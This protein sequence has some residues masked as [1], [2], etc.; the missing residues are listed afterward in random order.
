MSGTTLRATNRRGLIQWAIDDAELLNAAC[1]AFHPRS[2]HDL[3]VTGIKRGMAII[4]I[5]KGQITELLDNFCED[6]VILK[7]LRHG[8]SLVCGTSHGEIRLHDTTDPSCPA[9]L[10][11]QAHSGSISDLV[12]CGGS[13]LT[14]G[15]HLRYGV[16]NLETAIKAF[17]ERSL[18]PLIPIQFGAGAAFLK[19][20][21]KLT[22]SALML[23]QAGQLQT[24]DVGNQADIS[25]RQLNSM[26]YLTAFDISS[27][28]DALVYTDAENNIHLY[29]VSHNPEPRFSNLPSQTVFPDFQGELP[30]FDMMS[31]P[32]HV[33]GMPYYREELFSSW[34]ASLV[35]EVGRPTPKIDADILQ[36]M[37]IIDGIGYAPFHRRRR[38]NLAEERSV[39]N[40]SLDVPRFRS[41]K[42]KALAAGEMKEGMV[43][44]I[45]ED[46]GKLGLGSRNI[47]SYYRR[48][49]IKYSKFGIED[50]DFEFYN[51]TGF[52]GL[53][54]SFANSYCNSVLQIYNFSVS[55]RRVAQAHAFASCPREHCLL[56]EIGYIFGMLVDA[57]GQN[58]QSSNFLR[59][60]AESKEAQN[61]GL[62]LPDASALPPIPW[63]NLTQSF[64]R[65]LLETIVRESASTSGGQ[66]DGIGLEPVVSIYSKVVSKCQCGFETIKPEMS[67]VTDLLYTKPVLSRKDNQALQFSTILRSS[68]HREVPV[69]GWCQACRQ[70]QPA[71]IRRLVHS[72]PAVLNVN[73]MV[74]NPDQW[75]HWA[76]K[77]WPPLR[78]GVTLTSGKVQVLQGR[79]LDKRSGDN[80]VQHYSLRGIV[81]E[82]RFD[83]EQTHMVTFERLADT[84]D[85]KWLLFNDFLV[86]EVSSEEA[87]S[88]S[89]PWKVPSVL[90]YEK[91]SAFALPTSLPR[92]SRLDLS[93]FEQT[94]PM[95]KN[96]TVPEGF[97]PLSEYEIAKPGTLIAI[98]AEF[99][100]LQQ[101]EI[102]IR[103]DGTRHT[104]QP[105]RLS[106]AR[107][108]VL[109]GQGE[110]IGRPFIDDYIATT[111]PIANYLTEFSGIHK[112][113]LDPESSSH[114]LVTLKFAYKRLHALV[115][116][117]C[118]F[119]GHGLSSDFRIIN[120]NLPKEQVIDTVEIFY[121]PDKQRKLSLRFLSWY[122]LREH[123]QLAE[124]DSIE[125][126]RTALLLYQKSLEFKADG[127]FDMRLQEV[128]EEGR[129]M[130]FKVPG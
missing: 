116:L 44:N 48:M 54:T 14:C 119:I 53:E 56:C 15:Y 82:I 86:R 1:M 89:G 99:V 120:L 20:H 71:N 65:F 64:N 33:V 74:Q 34:P 63:A 72:L 83:E 11:M 4:N 100:A 105:S 52:S 97:K 121:I 27:S 109:R 69:R 110:S 6:V 49:E 111:S 96:W 124:H 36:H 98:D 55:I 73:A 7:S 117:G 84:P 3:I 67:V 77:S 50:F 60:F 81:N 118:I 58:C 85:S 70:Y 10:R 128:Y 2:A 12:V 46:A 87:L 130:N 95:S 32:L 13:I 22:T 114:Y 107:V 126:A 5:E 18:R 19:C 123:I 24:V 29:A 91:T 115:R 125:D 102:E 122:F 101:E 23:S 16:Y 112:G 45:S 40:G 26:S 21:P 51:S 94:N 129:A 35:F 79:D 30:E 68:I 38:R 104:I 66:S 37:K 88:Y 57:R 39:T 41:E 108:S 93:I 61:L 92:S 47:P 113:D 31:D 28:G 75:R 90:S 9:T 62:V 17:D 8:K 25:L 127:T 42:A 106:L 43:E 80:R 76:G 103:S 59:A 78:I